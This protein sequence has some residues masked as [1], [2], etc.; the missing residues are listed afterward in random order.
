MKKKVE[1]KHTCTAS[2]YNNR[3]FENT[4]LFG[5]NDK[6]WKAIIETY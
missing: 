2:G 6:I 5:Y 1:F 4:S 3:L